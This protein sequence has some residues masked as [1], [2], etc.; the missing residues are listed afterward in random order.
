MKKNK[1]VINKIL[2]LII[3]VFTITV[4]APINNI[5]MANDGT[6]NEEEIE[7]NTMIEEY[8]DS[9]LQV[10]N[11]LSIDVGQTIQYKS[12]LHEEE[13]SI[14]FELVTQDENIVAINENKEFVGIAP[15]ETYITL[16][17]DAGTYLYQVQ[18]TS[19]SENNNK[20]DLQSGYT[21]NNNTAKYKLSP[22]SYS[23][24]IMAKNTN[25]RVFIDPGHGGTDPG[26]T[27][28][29]L[30]EKDLNLSIALK[31]QRIL[32]AQGIEVVMSRTTDKLL[33]L[34]QISSLVN[35]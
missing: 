5:A 18:V 15:G 8:S 1:N 31:V 26:A 3:L 21:M 11:G 25:Y 34:S 13:T 29:G 4:V 14:P 6:T 35:N 17:S 27:G 22:L 19:P 32:Q 2:C 30:K 23:S 9:N 20:L 33:Q 12:L 24:G 10:K 16:Q 7:L 28:N